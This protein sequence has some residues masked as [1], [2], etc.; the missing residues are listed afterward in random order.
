MFKKKFEEECH[1]YSGNNY[2]SAASAAPS[3][4]PSRP[5]S[6]AAAVAFTRVAAQE[7]DSA[8][9]HREDAGGVVVPTSTTIAGATRAKNYIK[10]G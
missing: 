4:A 2:N 6:S 10:R 5:V 3:V 1:R 9:D 8:E 7:Q